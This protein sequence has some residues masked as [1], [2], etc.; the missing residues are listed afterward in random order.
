MS[1]FSDQVCIVTGA[2]CGIGKAV[3]LRFAEEG[4]GVVAVDIDKEAVSLT[5]SEC[6][7]RSVGIQ[8]DIAEPDQVAALHDRIEQEFGRLD[9]QPKSKLKNISAVTKKNWSDTLFIFLS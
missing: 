5:A 1:Q 8:C 7:D 4:A 6:G 3:A 9:V 2:G